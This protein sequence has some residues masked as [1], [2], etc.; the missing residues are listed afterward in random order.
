M[1][2][3]NMVSILYD[4]AATPLTEKSGGIFSADFTVPNN[5][6]ELSLGITGAERGRYEIIAKY[7]VQQP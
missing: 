2:N 3:K 6:T 1:D 4:N 7:T 5:I